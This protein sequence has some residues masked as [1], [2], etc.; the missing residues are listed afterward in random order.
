MKKNTPKKGSYR[1]I[2]YYHTKDKC[3]YGVALEFN[4]VV[5]GESK[6]DAFAELQEAVPGY[7]ESANAIKGLHDFDFLNQTP[8]A[9]FKK[10]WDVSQKNEEIKSPYSSLISGISHSYA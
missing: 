6:V 3:W 10:I 9:E 2:V 5:S 4:L 7:I 8:E 1:W